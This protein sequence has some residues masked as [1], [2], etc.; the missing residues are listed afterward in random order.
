MAVFLH[1]LL[2][3]R[4]VVTGREALSKGVKLLQSRAALLS[5]AFAGP[6]VVYLGLKDTQP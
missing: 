1:D 6:E 5:R 3:D 4:G 2:I